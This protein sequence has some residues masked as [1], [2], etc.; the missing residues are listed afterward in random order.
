MKR[1]HFVNVVEDS[2]DSLPEEF[3]SRIIYTPFEPYPS[4]SSA[5]RCLTNPTSFLVIQ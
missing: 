2:L 1:E 5:E 4:C 3:R